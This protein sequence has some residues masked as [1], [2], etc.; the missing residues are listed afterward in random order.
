MLIIKY[1]GQPTD[2]PGLPRDRGTNSSDIKRGEARGES[3]EGQEGEG[4]RG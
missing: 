3:E 2:L 4:E 1:Q